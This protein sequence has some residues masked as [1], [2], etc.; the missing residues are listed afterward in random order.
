[1]RLGGC[2]YKYC[3]HIPWTIT[4]EKSAL[5]TNW[6]VSRLAGG[7]LV[8][9]YISIGEELNSSLHALWYKMRGAGTKTGT[10][11]YPAFRYSNSAMKDS[12]RAF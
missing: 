4:L 3:A 10:T 1:M 8:W 9:F 6:F 5:P 11:G 2:L 12:H 7:L